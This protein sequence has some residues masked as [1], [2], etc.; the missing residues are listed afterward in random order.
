M[1]ESTTR[2]A[3]VVIA[4]YRRPDHV[5]TCLEHIRRQTTTPSR[6]IVVDA[7]PDDLTRDVV[8]A[9]EDVEYRRNDLG[10]G[11]LAASRAIGVQ[12]AVEDVVAFIDDDAYAEP[13]WLAELLA[14]Y[15]DPTVGAVGGRADNDRPGEEREGLDSIGRFLADGTLTGNFGADPGRIVETDHMLGAN[16][17][18]RT[19]ALRAIGGIHDYYPGTCLRED[20][21]LSLRVKKAGYRIVF[22]PRAAALHVAGEY[23]KGKRFDLRYRFYGA[24]NHILLL[25]TTLGWTDAH[26]PRHLGKTLRGAI[27]ES[28]SGVLG[29]P[30]KRGLTAKARGIAGG[31]SRAAVDVAGTVV[32]LCASIRPVDRA[33]GVSQS[34]R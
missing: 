29:W 12:D 9:F 19:D 1:G 24:R 31:V 30:S 34:W 4:T 32:G 21:D 16:M 3:L 11:T 17:S 5:R 20:S 14:A 22:A 7:S 33:A 18:V 28:W 2:A 27:K 8:T 6:V 15:D 26:L 25:T 10:A 23:A 13:Q